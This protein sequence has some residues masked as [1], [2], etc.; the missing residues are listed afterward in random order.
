MGFTIEDDILALAD[1]YDVFFLDMFGVLFNG[2]MLYEKTLDTLQQLKSLGKQ[3]IIISNATQLSSDAKN[4]YAQ[5]KMMEGEHYD[6]FITSGEFLHKM[7]KHDIGKFYEEMGREVHTVKCMFMGNGNIFDE[8]PLTRVEN[9]DD[10]DFLY[11][12]IPRTPY[13]AIRLDDIYNEHGDILKIEEVLDAKW[14]NCHDGQHRDGLKSFEHQLE[15]CL[16]KDKTLVVANP[17]IFAV[18]V[19]DGHH[20]PILTQGSIGAH[21]KKMGGKVVYF[22]KPFS[23]I[24][25]FAKQYVAEGKRIAMVGDTPWTDIV[26]ANSAGIRIPSSDW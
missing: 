16:E 1:S 19:A 26:G 11:V 18:Y 22:G 23:G 6:E 4:G 12:G 14:W 25:D 10:A 13:G 20:Y 15:I 8:T 21:Y 17:D 24:F 7:L 9:Y 2:V 5:R 3:I